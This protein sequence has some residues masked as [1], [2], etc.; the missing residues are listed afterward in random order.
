MTTTAPNATTMTTTTTA[1]T[2]AHNVTTT[3]TTMNATTMAT[4]DDW[5]CHVDGTVRWSYAAKKGED[6]TRKACRHSN[7]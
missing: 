3:T 4:P 2:T 1:T 7:L 6:A 5:L